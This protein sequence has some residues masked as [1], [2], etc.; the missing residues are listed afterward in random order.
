MEV[1]EQSGLFFK[2]KNW[3]GFGFSSDTGSLIYSTNFWT[4][5]NLHISL[6][7]EH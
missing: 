7:P 5:S 4:K 3:D 6:A 2:F 1:G